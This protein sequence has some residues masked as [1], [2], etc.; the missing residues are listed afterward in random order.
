MSLATAFGT[1]KCQTLLKDLEYA[2]YR[3]A[4]TNHNTSSQVATAT[5][6]ASGD[7]GKAIAAATLAQGSL[8]APIIAARDLLE[9]MPEPWL[10]AERI[11]DSGRRVP[12]FGNSFYKTEIDPSFFPVYAV[13][14]PALQTDIM[15]IKAKVLPKLH[16]N[17]AII[18]AAVCIAAELPRGVEPAIFAY[19]RIPAWTKRCLEMKLPKL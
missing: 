15:A 16:P 19:C 17:A 13:L 4:L 1:E 8:H 10:T 14:P 18:T 5:Y 6:A 9:S 12:G 3:A 2:H 7:L 11:V